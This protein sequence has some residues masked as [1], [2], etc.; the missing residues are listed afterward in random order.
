MNT[1]H[2]LFKYLPSH[3]MRAMVS[4][5]ESV[6]AQVTEVR[7]RSGQRACVTFRGRTVALETTCTQSDIDYAVERMCG[8]SR[9]SAEES[10]RSGYREAEIF[11]ARSGNR[12]RTA[13][14]QHLDHPEKSG[15]ALY[16]CR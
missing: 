3:I 16:L 15:Q 7:L 9:Y 1:P 12:P 8:F 5:D 10:L 6:L 11:H 4:L 13:G 14:Q 2:G